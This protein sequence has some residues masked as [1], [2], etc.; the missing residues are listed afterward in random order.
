MVSIL[1][2]I[3]ILIAALLIIFIAG[4]LLLRKLST[5]RAKICYSIIGCLALAL[6]AAGLFIDLQREKKPAAEPSSQNI[7]DRREKERNMDMI[8]WYDIDYTKNGWDD[9]YPGHPG[10]VTANGRYRSTTP[11]LGL[12]DQREPETARQHLYWMEALGCNVI[13][14]DWTNYNIWHDPSYEFNYN[15]YVYVN[16]E[17]LLETAQATT[18]F[19]APKIYVTVRMMGEDTE[20]LK[21]SVDD[22]YQLYE[23]FKEQW[24]FL[25]DGTADADKPFLVIFAD[26]PY[27]TKIQ[28]GELPYQDERF[29]IRW[30]NGFLSYTEDENGIH[31]IPGE[32]PLWIFVEKER[33]DNGYYE[34]FCKDSPQGGVE[35]MFACVVGNCDPES[36]ESD[37]MNHIIDGKTTFERH[38]RMVKE[39]QPQ[40][41]LVLRFNYAKAWR[42]EPQEG[43][44]LYESSHIEPNEDF[45]FLVFNNVMKNLYDLNDWTP[46]PPELSQI[47]FN[48]DGSIVLALDSFPLE[49]RISHSETMD[50]AEWNYLNVNTW[51][52]VPAEF[53]G[54][55]FCLQTRNAFGESNIFP[56]TIN[57]E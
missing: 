4:I 3:L 19:D 55:T 33:E 30:S 12:Y 9:L 35:Q 2:K 48:E 14:L 26:H 45:G 29:N 34:V 10:A 20:L 16:S 56:I 15:R 5:A 36:G 40:A 37:P 22:V 52:S 13:T 43:I 51:I 31:R 50:G 53:S 46:A 6:V 27:L 11:L 38:L 23:Q 49:Y 39:L 44:S 41:L 32:T 57:K 42:E 7:Q 8:M 28:K 25:D 24:Y 47:D 21:E 18:D 54:E 1:N 17:V